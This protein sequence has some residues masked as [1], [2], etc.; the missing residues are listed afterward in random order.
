MTTKCT[1]NYRNDWTSEQ[2]DFGKR[3]SKG[4]MIGYHV[5]TVTIEYVPLTEEQLAKSYSYF[6]AEPRIAY[7]AD[8]HA[9]RDGKKYGA[10][11]SCPAFPTREERDAWIAR[12]LKDGEKY[13]ARKAAK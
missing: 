1:M 9:T 3:D 7:R 11:N 8:V 12:R 5:S 2:H 10:S 4:R 6:L 13:A